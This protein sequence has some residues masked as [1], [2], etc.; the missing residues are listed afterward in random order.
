MGLLERYRPGAGA[1]GVRVNA[2]NHAAWEDITDAVGVTFLG[3]PYVR[4]TLVRRLPPF[5]MRKWWIP[6][7]LGR[8]EKFVAAVRSHCPEG[9]PLRR[10]LG[11]AS[12][13]T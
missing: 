2:V 10:A 12:A 8:G 5:F 7:Y 3:L 6:L 1:D 11:L 4:L 9:H 13:A